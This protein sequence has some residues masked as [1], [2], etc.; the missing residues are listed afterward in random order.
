MLFPLLFKEGNMLRADYKKRFLKMRHSL[1]S[2]HELVFPTFPAPMFARSVAGK[3]FNKEKSALSPQV[4]DP[5]PVKA[6]VDA[7]GVLAETTM[8]TSLV[9]CSFLWAMNPLRLPENRH[10]ASD[11]IGDVVKLFVLKRSF[12]I[13]NLGDH[14]WRH[15]EI[16]EHGCVPRG[17]FLWGQT[18][19]S[20]VLRSEWEADLALRLQQYILPT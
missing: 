9:L 19:L 7:P 1:A 16:N 15:V 2:I 18:P 20:D 6:R 3:V 14:Q 11:C 5:L 10:A 4:P 12:Q 8:D 13:W 17:E